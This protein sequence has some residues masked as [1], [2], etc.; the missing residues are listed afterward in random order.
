MNQTSPN[1]Q[2]CALTGPRILLTDTNRWPVT[3]RLAIAFSR[4]GGNVAVLCPVP[5][6]PAEKVRCVGRIFEYSGLRSLASLRMAIEAFNPDIVVPSCDRGVQHLHELHAVS[7]SQ[8]S[9]GNRLANLI[10]YSLGS[11]EAF[12]I[13]SS[14]RVL[15]QVAS[16]EGI[17]VPETRGIESL[18]DL[19][20]WNFESAAPRVLKAD[21]T[22]GGRGVRIAL[23]T[24]ES[25][26][27]FLELTKE[28]NLAELIKRV[29]LNR[30]RGWELY[31]WKRPR[32]AVIAQSLIQGRPANCAVVC[33]QGEILAGIAVEVILAQGA[34]G[35]AAVVQ[36]VEGPEM[37]I[38]AERIARRLKL[39]GFFGLDFIIEEQTGKTYLIEMNPRCTPPCPLTLGK[40]QDLVAALWAELANRP[41]DQSEPLTTMSR[42][43]YF[44]QAKANSSGAPDTLLDACYT[45]IP[46]GEPDLIQ[47]LL[48]PWEAR[49]VA[50][51]LVDFVRRRQGLRQKPSI[52][53]FQGALSANATLRTEGSSRILDE[54]SANS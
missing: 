2:E 11:P 49:S 30:D 35:P 48:H 5:G 25:E 8:G 13:V 10:E 28:G 12:P 39:S 29:F 38:A 6:H 22:W 4:L 36:I 19:R 17:L 23:T 53:V 43:A 32:P 21:G 50:G 42:I 40:G 7:Q 20:R 54:Q 51:Q 44:P 41:L 15:L 37:M 52:C 31:D 26:A 18:A 14:R 47:E 9:K 34:T 3:P 33:R 24:K 1:M 27:A 16:S 46:V 45:D